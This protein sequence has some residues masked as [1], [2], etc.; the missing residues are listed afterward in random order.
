[1]FSSLFEFLSEFERY[2]HDIVTQHPLILGQVGA[3][4]DRD[5]VRHTGVDAEG[6]DDSPGFPPIVFLHL[7]L[8]S[9]V[10]GGRSGSDTVMVA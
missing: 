5:S 8:G 1:M 3:D 2:L 4:G 10:I 7:L 6:L 9:G